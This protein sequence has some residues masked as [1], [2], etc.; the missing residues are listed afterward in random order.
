MWYGLRV[1]Y[2]EEMQ[3]GHLPLASNDGD[4]AAREKVHL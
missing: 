1:Q 2:G 3:R 4:D